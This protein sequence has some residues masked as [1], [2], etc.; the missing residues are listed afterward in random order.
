MRVKPLLP[1]FL[2]RAWM[3]LNLKVEFMGISFGKCFLFSINNLPTRF[4]K[5]ITLGK[6]FFW[7]DGV[8]GKWG[9]VSGG[10][11]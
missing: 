8:M 1:F 9:A 7:G 5:P 2:L 6:N 11:F 3:S 4:R 10:Q